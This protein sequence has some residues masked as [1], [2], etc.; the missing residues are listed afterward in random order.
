MHLDGGI[1]LCIIKHFE[2]R[3]SIL[4]WWL[5]PLVNQ[6]EINMQ[7]SISTRKKEREDYCIFVIG[8]IPKNFYIII[9]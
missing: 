3:L 1:D 8:M 2:T 6:G 9:D 4:I 5:E 7:E